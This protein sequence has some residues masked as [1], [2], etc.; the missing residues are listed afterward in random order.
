[1]KTVYIGTSG[2]DYGIVNLKQYSL[3]HN[4][5]EI[6]NTFYRYPSLTSSTKWFDD[7]TDNFN[8]CIKVN[9]YITHT[10]RLKNIDFTL[11]D[12][13]DKLKPLKHK[14]A[15]L[16]FQFD[17]RFKYNT[18]NINR[19]IHVREITDLKCVFEF[20]DI[21]WYDKVVYDIFKQHNLN[22][23]IS[24]VNNINNWAGNLHT[25]FTHDIQTYEPICDFTYLRL[26]GTSGT[27]EG[28]YVNILTTL[29]KFI[30][31]NNTDV[32]VFFDNT[33]SATCGTQSCLYDSIALSNVL[34][35]VN[36]LD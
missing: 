8:F 28:S 35:N 32:Y 27:Y 23:V 36:Y 29:S 21:S 25:G 31:K 10:K 11:K 34:S 20:R 30:K 14:L 15:C 19:I 2:Y 5:V 22:I 16:L 4:S 18:I 13:I 1:M 33:N 24:H 26:H 7:T 17:K 3:I 12:F 9:K 6:N